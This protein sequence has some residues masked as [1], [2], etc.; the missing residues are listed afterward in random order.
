MKKIPALSR[1]NVLPLFAGAVSL[2][3]LAACEESRPRL[4]GFCGSDGATCPPGQMCYDGLCMPT[5]SD[6]GATCPQGTTCSADLCVPECKDDRDCPSGAASTWRCDG[7]CYAVGAPGKVHAR[8]VEPAGADETHAVGED[9]T[10][11][12]EADLTDLV[13]DP[14]F[15][16]VDWE[17]VG[18]PPPDV[19]VTLEPADKADALAASGRRV[20]LNVPRVVDATV[21]QLRVIA[22]GPS[23]RTASEELDITVLNDI[24]E[25]P[26]VSSLDVV[27]G[28][29]EVLSPGQSVELRVTATDPNPGDTL[30]ASWS[31]S[32]QPEGI[33]AALEPN[34]LQATLKVPED[35]EGSVDFTVSCTVS[36][37][38]V[39]I[40]ISLVLHALGSPRPPA[41]DCDDGDACT[42]D[43]CDAEGQC[44]HAAVACDDGDPCTTDTC[45][46]QAGCTNAPV[47][48]DDGIDCTVD[49]CRP[50]TGDCGHEPTEA[51]ECLVDSDCSSPCA[52]KGV[53]QGGVCAWQDPR[54]QGSPCTLGDTGGMCDGTGACVPFESFVLPQDAALEFSS[55]EALTAV[56][57]A[58]GGLRVFAGGGG[59]GS[60][61]DGTSSNAAQIWELTPPQTPAA[62]VVSLPSAPLTDAW[63][64][65]M[66]AFDGTVL[67]WDSAGGTWTPV[68]L[69][70]GPAPP[71]G[72]ELPFVSSVWSPD[73]ALPLRF[74]VA[75]K[76]PSDSPTLACAPG[77]E[78]ANASCAPLPW[79]AKPPTYA[80]LQ[81]VR[82]AQVGATATAWF[83]RD[84]GLFVADSFDWAAPGQ[85]AIE[86]VCTV[87]GDVAMPPCDSTSDLTDISVV[88]PD[89]VWV[90]NAAG[91]LYHFDGDTWTT[92]PTPFPPVV[93]EVLAYPRP[94]VIH[95]TPEAVWVARVVAPACGVECDGNCVP[96]EC[97]TTGSDV[98]A[99]A[100]FV[101]RYD[102]AAQ[103]WNF[104]Q[105]AVLQCPAPEGAFVTST[106]VYAL[107]SNFAPRAL[108]VT[109][110]GAIYLGGTK[111]TDPTDPESNTV[112]FVVRWAPSP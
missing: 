47:D 106:C 5:C 97:P 61:P 35:L 26:V 98:P 69:S 53:C 8:I 20:R 1:R 56:S 90:C 92:I 6:P 23:G 111:P 77:A 42:E 54:G 43:T 14:K 44:H 59:S 11:L 3:A 101:G 76:F 105:A 51:C 110:T 31:V 58:A 30:V 21:L 45:D 40:P 41:C 10:V 36:D 34:G 67:G 102:R 99:A 66:I 96:A 52:S 15:I 50:D 9:G 74:V 104:S 107:A 81:R 109:P 18:P 17:L 93:L 94:Q 75:S 86:S 12:L 68:L 32:S 63:A 89:D 25:P 87:D 39:D 108:L 62:P 64:G 55:V 29:P 85:S 19:D 82:G 72:A 100:W 13:A 65:A 46:P 73:P 37:G 24:D 78:P 38:K 33:A 48:C 112:P 95:A 83:L 57:E 91:D 79:S 80:F 49:T 84:D 28:A 27:G 103:T 60:A 4:G 16:V 2:L 22:R 7:R 71:V 88:A 70:P